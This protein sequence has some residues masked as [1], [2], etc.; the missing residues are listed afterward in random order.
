M[1]F[2]KI[3]TP[4]HDGTGVHFFYFSKPKLFHPMYTLNKLFFSSADSISTPRIQSQTSLRPLGHSLMTVPPYQMGH[5]LIVMF[6]GISTPSHVINASG[7]LTF[8]NQNSSTHM[9]LP[10]GVFFSPV[11]SISIPRTQSPAIIPNLYDFNDSAHSLPP[12]VS[13][14]CDYF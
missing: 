8:P 7:F 10:V 6:S 14:R 4:S 2:T 1:L 11:H 9:L 5:V 12:H 3:S 13:I